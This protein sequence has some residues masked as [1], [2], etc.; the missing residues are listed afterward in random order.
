VR[1]VGAD[2]LR[3]SFAARFHK[4]LTISARLLRTMA[5]C[6]SRTGWCKSFNTTEKQHAMAQQ[7]KLMRFVKAIGAALL[8]CGA[9]GAQAD[10]VGSVTYGVDPLGAVEAQGFHGV[11]KG[12]DS[13]GINHLLENWGGNWTLAAKDNTGGGGDVSNVVNDIRFRVDAGAQ[14]SEGTWTL[15]GEGLAGSLLHL[16]LVVVLKSSTYYA[17]YYFQNIEFDGS[18]GGGWLSPSFNKKGIRQDLSH[19]SVYVR[20]GT[21]EGFISP[22]GEMLPGEMPMA[23]PVYMPP[24]ADG[25]AAAVPEPGSLALAGLGLLGLLGIGR[26]SARRRA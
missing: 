16:D 9:M 8:A 7:S 19:L 20:P 22:Q 1:Y 13:K 3:T 21:D 5:P 24:M 23:M 12:N 10:V 25:M 26:R 11:L 6:S 17:L 2:T 14:E 4:R 18:S 15:T